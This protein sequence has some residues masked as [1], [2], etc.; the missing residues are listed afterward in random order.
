MTKNFVLFF[1]ILFSVKKSR[2]IMLKIIEGNCTLKNIGVAVDLTQWML[3]II[4]TVLALIQ[5]S[6]V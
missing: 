2:L 1:Q 3:N 4:L 5:T 6:R